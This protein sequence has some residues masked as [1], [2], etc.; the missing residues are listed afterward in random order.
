MKFLQ[1]ISDIGGEEQKKKSVILFTNFELHELP[2]KTLEF[3]CLNSRDAIWHLHIRKNKQTR[4]WQDK[5]I[6]D[7][8]FSGGR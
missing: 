7:N 5:Q 1:K 4:G 2:I 3:Y 8:K 6:Q